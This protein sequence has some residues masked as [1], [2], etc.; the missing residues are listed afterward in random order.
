MTRPTILSLS[1]SL[2]LGLVAAPHAR[3]G[4]AGP[5]RS[6]TSPTRTSHLDASGPRGE[7]L[8]GTVGGLAKATSVLARARRQDPAALLLHSGDVLQGDLFF[9]AYFGVPELTWM[10]SMG[11]DAMT[12]GNHEFDPGPEGLAG[13]LAMAFGEGSVPLLSANAGSLGETGLG[14]FVSP[15][16]LKDAGGVQVGVFGLTVPDDPLCMNAPVTLDPDVAAVAAREVAALRASGAEVIV[17]L[18]PDLLGFV[19]DTALAES[20]DGID[21]VLGGHD[22]LVLRQAVRRLLA[23]RARGPRPPARPAPCR[24]R[25]PRP[26]GGGRNRRA[27]R[28][29]APP[30]GCGRAGRAVRRRRRRGVEGGDRGHLRRPSLHAPGGHGAPRPPDPPPGRRPR[31]GRPGRQPRDGRL[32]CRGPHRRRVHEHR[33]P[34]RGDRAR[35]ARPGRPLPHRELRLRPRDG[36]RLP[37]RAASPSRR[38]SRRSRS[39]SPVPGPRTPSSRTSPGSASHTTL[40]GPRSS[41][42]TSRASASAENRSTP[43][44]APRSP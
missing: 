28:V 7:D 2:S 3:G 18:S 26:E 22:H 27:R 23:V 44:A 25:P 31:P 4:R 17:L 39:A 42:S 36:P 41:G 1:L 5:S 40:R 21:V 20:V 24:R 10:V 13:I 38:S 8:S 43:R 11:F 34:E 30:G 32:P 35:A 6:S 16:L 14:S 37:S 15:S 33:L 12:L 9:N 29:R 19:R